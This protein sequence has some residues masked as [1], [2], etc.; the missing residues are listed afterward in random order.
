MNDEIGVYIHIPFCYSKCYYC[1]FVSYANCESQ[2]GRYIN[3]VYK[4]ILEKAEILSQ[5]KVKTIYIGGGTPSYLDAK[6]I[7]QLLDTLMLVINKEDIEEITIEVNPNSVTEEKLRIYKELGINRISIGLQ[8]IYNDVLKNIGRA[9]TFE[10]FEKT[11]ELVNRVGFDNIS[12]DLIYPLP[13]LD[14]ERLKKTVDYVVSLKRKNVKHVSIYN[15]EVH[16]DTKLFYLLN[17]KILSLADEDEEYEMYK[18]I[19]DTL[20]NNGYHRYEISNYALEG[21][22]S[23]HN[24]RYWNQE[25]YLGFGNNA[26]SFFGGARFSNVKEMKEYIEN[27]EKDYTTKDY[28]RYEQLDTS[29]LMKEYVMLALRK[30]EGLSFISFKNKYK[31]DI[32]EVFE[33]EIKELIEEG[34]IQETKTNVFLT[35]RG[36]EVA[37]LVWEKFV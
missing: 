12:V 24:L 34:L 23:K 10:D 35:Q 17:Y 13:G 18:Y 29:D 22:E 25:E 32:H 31:K 9:H 26:A 27:T 15:L 8:S 19:K 20:E 21:Y 37:N 4:E 36:L 3:G 7:K 14:L 16:E 5:Y 28:D 30:T 2:I 11:L 33:K 1:D 6:Y